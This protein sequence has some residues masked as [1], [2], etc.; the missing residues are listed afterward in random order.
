M[1]AGPAGNE[2]SWTHKVLCFPSDPGTGNRAPNSISFSLFCISGFSLP[3]G[4]WSVCMRA[5]PQGCTKERGGRIAQAAVREKERWAEAGDVKFC[6][7]RVHRVA[8]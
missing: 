1:E 8:Q 5:E 7:S 2:A 3:G 4:P 6:P